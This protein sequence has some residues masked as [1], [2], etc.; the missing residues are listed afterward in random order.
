[1]GREIRRVPLDWEH[2]RDSQGRY[3]PLYDETYKARCQRFIIR[4]QSLVNGGEITE[5]IVDELENMNYLIADR[6]MCRPDWKEDV[7]LG[8]CLYENVSEGTPVSPVFA[9]AAGLREW[10]V[11]EYNVPPTSADAFME[12][13]YAPSFMVYGDGDVER[14]IDTLG[15]N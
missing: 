9:T 13:G 5:T 2:P 15:N 3:I 7:E 6:E 12:S 4:F 8:Y 1:M 14:G 11:T 10:L